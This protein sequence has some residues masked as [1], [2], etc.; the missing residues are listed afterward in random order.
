MENNNK[1]RLKKEV[2]LTSI[3]ILELIL[4][5]VCIVTV[6]IKADQKSEKLVSTEKNIHSSAPPTSPVVESSIAPSITPEATKTTPPA[7][8]TINPT[9]NPSTD[10][11]VSSDGKLNAVIKNLYKD[12][13]F[14]GDSRTEGLQLK[15]G[16]SSAKFIT[17]RGLTVSTAMK[18]KV[19]RLKNGS[20]G[21]V[22]DALKEG[23][24]KKVFVM[25]GINELGWPYTS[26]FQEQYEKLIREIQ[27]VQPDAQIYVQS[28][29]PVT[30]TKSDSSTIY[31]LK[32]V[33]KFNQAITDMTKKLKL[34]YLDVQESI[35]KPGT[36][37]PEDA[38]VDGVH[39]TK[40]ACFKWLNY[41]TNH[42]A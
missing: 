13:V 35:T 37:L 19:I 15:T 4:V 1:K 16:L 34:N 8:D 30:K 26:T 40:A 10:K 7:T 28:I 31:T 39:L 27:K 42:I 32:Q 29:I 22:V 20:K 6:K 2:L 21:T 38:A 41:I 23:T 17:H 36:Y 12:S 14:I 3:V 9:K 24:Y 5:S 18:E 11:P 25:F 33:K